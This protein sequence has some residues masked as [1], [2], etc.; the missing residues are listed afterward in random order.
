MTYDPSEA[1][2]AHRELPD[3]PVVFRRYLESGKIINTY[4]WFE[5]FAQAMVDESRL[6]LVK[7][8]Q[9]IGDLEDAKNQT[10][11]IQNHDMDTDDPEARK[12]GPDPTTFSEVLPSNNSDWKRELQARFLHSLHELDILGLIK[13]TG[14]KRDHVVRII[15]DGPR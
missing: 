2:P 11:D 12:E 3:T 14:R 10:A 8:V 4:D 9:I 5:S 13:P 1:G 15:F 6:K 7:D